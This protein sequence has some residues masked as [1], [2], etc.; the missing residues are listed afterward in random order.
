MRVTH[1]AGIIV[2]TSWQGK[3]ILFFV[4]NIVDVIQNCHLNGVFYEIEELQIIARYFKADQ[5]FVDIGSNVGNHA[6]YVEKFLS[7]KSILLIEPNPEAIQILQLNLLLNGLSKVDT[8]FLGTGLSDH[9]ETA[10]IEI[11]INNLGGARLRP[12]ANAG[13]RIVTGDSLLRDRPVDFIKLDVEG[14]EMPA[15][16][17]LQ[18][19]ISTNRPTIF[20]E[21]ENENIA[22]FSD[23]MRLHRYKIVEQFRRYQLN[24]NFL[25]VPEE[26]SS[27]PSKRASTVAEAPSAPT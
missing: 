6:I 2:E 3:R 10:V 21:V 26:R 5:A 7:P 9:E 24:E 1:K 13:V 12:Q 19:T 8:Q 20:I 11:P 17:G 16:R 4:K 23:W 18:G 25:V 15:L 27:A 22:E 14:L